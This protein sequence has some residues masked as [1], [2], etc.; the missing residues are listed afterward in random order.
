M[1]NE[2]I[3]ELRD[4]ISEKQADVNEKIAEAQAKASEGDLQGAKDIK[5]QIDALKAEIEKL[6]EDLKA[7]EELADLQPEQVQEEQPQEEKSNKE[8]EVRSM[9]KEKE[10]LNPAKEELRSFEQYIRSKGEVRDGLTTQNAEV[11]LPKEVVT[12]V[13]E[14]KQASYDLANYVTVKK[15]GTKSGSFPVA[16]RNAGILATKDELLDI[17]DVASD[18]FIDVE[19]DV[20]TRAGKIALSNEIIEDSAIDV[21]AEVKKQLQRMVVNTNNQNIINLLKGFTKVSAT[22]LDDVKKVFNV[23]LDP[24]LNKQVIVN[25]SAY[26]YLDTL[27]DV[28][29]RYLLQPDLKAQSGKSLF[30]AEVIVVSDSLLPNGGTQSSPKYPIIVGDFEESIAVFNRNQVTAQWEKFDSYSQGL[31]VVVRNDYKVV[32]PDATRYIEL[33]PATQG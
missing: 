30:G 11:L 6:Q 1:L 33:T 8:G 22:G 32:D 24:A 25:Q 15:V 9:K 14:L 17:A 4:Q 7:L 26:N 27:K 10:I 29:G 31:S 23:D 16:K 2:K 5:A 19:W 18:M 12:E 28:D 21:V 3:K 13:L 20:Q